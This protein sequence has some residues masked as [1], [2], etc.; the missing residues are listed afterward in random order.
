MRGKLCI[1]VSLLLIA[2]LLGGCTGFSK[3]ETVAQGHFDFYVSDLGTRAF[4]SAYYWE[5]DPNDTLIEIPDTVG[6]ADVE[7]VGGYFGTGNPIPMMITT[8][9]NNPYKAETPPE[10]TEAQPLTFTLSIGKNVRSIVRV[11]TPEYLSALS[12]DGSV[13]WYQPRLRVELREENS[14]FYERNGRLYYKE[15]DRLVDAIGYGAVPVD[16]KI[17]TLSEYGTMAYSTEYEWVKTLT[18]ARLTKYEGDWQYNENTEREDCVA[19]EVEGG[20]ELYDEICGLLRDND[21]TAWDGFNKTDPDVLDGGGFSFS[22]ALE[23]GSV[24]SASGSNAY[25]GGYGNF[26]NGLRR[27]LDRANEV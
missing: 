24:V 22:M 26:L 11:I 16:F 15:D 25:P 9:G 12:I 3:S 5:G 6:R 20:K 2:A 8:R 17:G 4:P 7:S 13:R 19:A 1:A 14:K 23:D 27:I 21:V 10:G 18:G